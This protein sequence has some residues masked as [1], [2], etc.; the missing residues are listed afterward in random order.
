[1]EFLI[2]LINVFFIPSAIFLLWKKNGY[3]SFRELPISY[4]GTT[5]TKNAFFASV[6]AAAAFEAISIYILFSSIPTLKSPSLV[7][8]IFACLLSLSLSG[9][10]FSPQRSFIHRIFVWFMGVTAVAWSFFFH[11]KLLTVAPL[12]GTVGLLLSVIALIGVPVLYLIHKSA[13]VSQLLFAGVVVLW[14]ILM[15]VLIYL[16]A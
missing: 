8:L 11:L 1:M 7:Y 5:H 10:T 12:Y 14:N 6:A 15:S 2:V 3:F 9:I 13:G 16:H 4:T